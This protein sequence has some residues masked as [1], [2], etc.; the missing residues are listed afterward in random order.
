M[1]LK[2]PMRL[3]ARR[4]SRL[5]LAR[6]WPSCSTR[7]SMVS[8]GPKRR[9]VAVATRSSRWVALWRRP[10]ALS[11]STRGVFVVAVIVGLLGDMGE[12][13]VA[14]ERV[15]RDAQVAHARVVGQDDGDGRRRLPGACPLVEEMRDRGGGDGTALERRGQCGLECGGTVSV[16]QTGQMLGLGAQ[17]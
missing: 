5:R 13:V 7:S 15:G 6:C 9:L 10:R 2:R 16:E 8:V 1:D 4:R 17:G 11:R 12:R 14:G 3:R